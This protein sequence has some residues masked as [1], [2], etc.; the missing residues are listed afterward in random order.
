M[1]KHIL[2]V[3]VSLLAIH[4]LC[5]GQNSANKSAKAMTQS[6]L[7]KAWIE[8][9]KA[10]WE[11]IKNKQ[12]DAFRRYYADDFKSVS[13]DGVHDI[14]QEMEGVR[15]VDLKSYSL[16][17]LKVL[18][19]NKGTAIVTFKVTV[20]GSYKE[21]DISGAYYASSVWV[22]RGGKWRAIFYTEVKAQ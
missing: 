2:L 6:S 13:V 11:T 12:F 17:D 1:K 7:D 15:N 14:K 8:R 10:V 21:Q 22:N 5:F 18:T 16:T 4:S 9:E 3:S 20:Q 19:P